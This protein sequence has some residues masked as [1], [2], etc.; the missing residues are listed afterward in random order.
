M[1]PPIRYLEAMTVQL[2][3]QNRR[4][5]HLTYYILKRK[6]ARLSPNQKCDT[7]TTNS[8]VRERRE[9]ICAYINKLLLVCVELAATFAGRSHTSAR[10]IFEGA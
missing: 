1:E 9:K 4:P 3:V 8:C 6:P 2:L 10:S 7:L 5:Q